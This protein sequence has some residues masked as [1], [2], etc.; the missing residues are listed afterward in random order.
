VRFTNVLQNPN[1]YLKSPDS[2]FAATY[3]YHTE[4][5]PL[6]LTY[7]GLE[8]GK[9]LSKPQIT[10]PG[11]NYNASRH[12]KI[13]LLLLQQRNSTYNMKLCLHN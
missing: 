7:K 12:E 9:L 4:H 2:E 11:E 1:S 8:L 3:C 5:E 6:C 13:L 10:A